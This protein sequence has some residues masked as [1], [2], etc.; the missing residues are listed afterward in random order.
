MT[1][2]EVSNLGRYGFMGGR[3]SSLVMQQGQQHHDLD[4]GEMDDEDDDPN[5]G[6]SHH[7]PHG[8]RHG[9]RHGHGATG[10]WGFFLNV[11]GF[12]RFTKGKAAD[13]FA[14]AAKA[15][16]PFDIGII[17]NCMDF[18]TK[19]REIGVEYEKLY[20]VPPE[21]FKTTMERRRR[22][23]DEEDRH[24]E[25]VNPHSGKI[26]GIASRYIPGLLGARL[27]RSNG[28]QVVSM[29]EEA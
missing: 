15:S 9:H 19:G 4:V 29:N 2:L 24:D 16:N 21:G 12:D 25:M 14:R 10:C 6:H 28:Y 1:T 23:V 17:S 27:P 5:L 22:V 18:W 8:H 20:D 13:G 3:G 7:H 26:K 11:L